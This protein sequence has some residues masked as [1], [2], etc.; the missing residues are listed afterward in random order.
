MIQTTCQCTHDAN[1]GNKVQ[2]SC[3]WKQESCAPHLLKVLVEV[4]DG[5]FSIGSEVDGA[6][7]LHDQRAVKEGKC[8]R[9]GAMNR[10]A[11]GNAPV[12]E[13]PYH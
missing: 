12:A 4:V 11:D 7:A 1:Q 6:A 2:Q 9:R 10:C 13:L 5:R 8:V 3:A